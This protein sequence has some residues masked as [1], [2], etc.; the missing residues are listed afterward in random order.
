MNKANTNKRESDMLNHT[1]PTLNER[2][3]VMMAVVSLVAILAIAA[4]VYFAYQAGRKAPAPTVTPTPAAAASDK[5]LT[6]VKALYAAYSPKNDLVAIKT[7]VTPELYTKLGQPAPLDPVLCN[8]GG[9]SEPLR[10]AAGASSSEVI[11]KQLFKGNETTTTDD[12][13][14]VI[15]LMVRPS[16][17][18]VTEITCASL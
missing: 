13:D 11:V 7:Y 5:A 9:S 3:D 15:K 6:N 17:G 4:A 14:N 16:D 2:G 18:L 8:Q 1:K 12:Q 10:F